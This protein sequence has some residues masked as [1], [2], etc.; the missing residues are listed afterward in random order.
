M[1][2]DLE[3][4]ISENKHHEPFTVWLREPE[5]PFATDHPRGGSYRLVCHWAFNCRTW[6]YIE[7]PDTLAFLRMVRRHVLD[8]DRV[9]LDWFELSWKSALGQGTR[10]LASMTKSIIGRGW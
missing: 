5:S 6:S 2:L 1:M 10:S 3:V 7:I 4:S 8:V 9:S